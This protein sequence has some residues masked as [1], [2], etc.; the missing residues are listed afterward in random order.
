MARIVVDFYDRLGGDWEAIEPA[1]RA[2]LQ[3]VEDRSPYANV[4]KRAKGLQEFLLETEQQRAG[5]LIFYENDD[6]CRIEYNRNEGGPK[7]S[8]HAFL[9]RMGWGYNDG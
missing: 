1:V 9:S 8:P 2:F 5:V 4:V 3:V 7:M 6:S